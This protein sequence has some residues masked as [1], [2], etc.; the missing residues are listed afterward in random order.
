MRNT[1]GTSLRVPGVMGWSE[2]LCAKPVSEAHLTEFAGPH[3][4]ALLRG[5]GICDSDKTEHHGM[6]GLGRLFQKGQLV[7]NGVRKHGSM[8]SAAGHPWKS[9]E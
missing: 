3:G 9:S 6:A 1:F 8:P 2:R 7:A 5:V 4:N